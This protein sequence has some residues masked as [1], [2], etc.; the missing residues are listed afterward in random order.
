MDD[1]RAYYNI[2]LMLNR[3]AETRRLHTETHGATVREALEHFARGR[4]QVYVWLVMPDH[5]HL[6]F[7]H[8]PPVKNLGNYVGRIK[9]AINRA[10]AV[11]RLAPFQWLDGFVSYPVWRE[12]LRDAR[13]YILANPVRGGLVKSAQAYDLKDTPADLP[14][15]E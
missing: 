12:N 5:I 14:S 6:L 11:R 10:M 1:G 13:E 9:H 2:T 4:A 15:E 7:S 8:V 3:G